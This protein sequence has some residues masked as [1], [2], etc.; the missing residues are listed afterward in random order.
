MMALGAFEWKV[1]RKKSIY[2]PTQKQ[3]IGEY[4]IIIKFMG[5]IRTQMC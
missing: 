1:I 4:A 3:C 2:R 5:Y